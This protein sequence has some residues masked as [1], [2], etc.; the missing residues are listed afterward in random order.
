MGFFLLGE[1]FRQAV[2]LTAEVF[3]LPTRDL[4]LVEIH[5][6][7]A[8]A[9]QSPVRAA[10]EGGRH[11]QIAQQSGGP[12]RGSFRFR[13]RLG[14]EKQLGLVRQALAGEGRALAPSGIELPGLPRIRVVL[15]EDGGHAL[16]IFETHAG[17][18]DQELHGHMGRELAFAHLLL[19]G[20]GQKIDQGQ[21]PRNPTRAAIKAAPQLLASI[22]VALLQLLKQPALFQRRLVFGEAQ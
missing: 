13:G 7:G 17:D 18:R 22:T 21:P 19:D 3:D 11:L 20:L 6:R 10:D 1:T 4:A 2:Q 12:R 14:F 9:A 16:T 8:R 5:L 15:G